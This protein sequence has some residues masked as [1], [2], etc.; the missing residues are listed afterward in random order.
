M[1]EQ[2]L[3]AALRN[4][5]SEAFALLFDQYSDRVYRLAAGLLGDEDEAEG[6]VQE[7]FL[8]LFD[9]LDGFEGRSSLAT[10]LYRV[11]YNLSVDGLRRRRP[12]LS[13]VDGDDER[14]LPG[15]TNLADWR[16]APELQLSAQEVAAELDRAIAGLPEKLRGV[17]ILRE[18]EGLATDECAQVLGITAGAVKV[19]LHRARLLLRERLATTFAE[20]A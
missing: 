9:R 8:R 20:P 12:T 5:D 2:Q 7:T 16:D 15:A 19:R 10:W 4:R 3:L 14:A 11:A 6:V 18:I 1:N 13:L 17:F